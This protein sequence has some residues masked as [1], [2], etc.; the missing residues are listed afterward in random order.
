MTRL[1]G[2]RAR[3]EAIGRCPTEGR[4]AARGRG[5]A[6][7][8]APSF[9][10]APHQF[11]EYGAT[12]LPNPILY[13]PDAHRIVIDT[14][15]KI[16]DPE[17]KIEIGEESVGRES[18]VGQPEWRHLGIGERPGGTYVLGGDGYPQPVFEQGS[19]AAE[20]AY[21][22]RRIAEIETAIRVG[23]TLYGQAGGGLDLA[24]PF[25]AQLQF[26]P[27]AAVALA[28]LVR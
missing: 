2:R 3:R 27:I 26:H 24:R 11:Q 20:F 18:Q 6:A 25:A 4:P 22:A 28:I 12:I 10:G 8:C 15:K 7:G 17:L 23:G 13:E 9:P 14:V 16:A 1:R 5:W 19:R 21:G